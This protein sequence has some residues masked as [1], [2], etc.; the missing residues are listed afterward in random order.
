MVFTWSRDQGVGRDDST[1]LIAN[2]DAS[3]ATVGF[4]ALGQEL[5]EATVSWFSLE[6]LSVQTYTIIV[7]IGYM[8]FIQYFN[9][10]MI[11]A[12]LCSNLQVKVR[13]SIDEP[14]VSRCAFGYLNHTLNIINLQ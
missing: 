6:S 14:D 11:L 12:C 10:S 7:L 9:T 2:G 4:V 1:R 3:N 8:I 5:V 13:A